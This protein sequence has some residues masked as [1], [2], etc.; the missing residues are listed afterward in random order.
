MDKSNVAALTLKF[1][2]VPQI[3]ITVVMKYTPNFHHS[4]EILVADYIVQ[5]FLVRNAMRTN[6]LIVWNKFEKFLSPDSP[7]SVETSCSRKSQSS[8]LHKGRTITTKT[9]GSDRSSDKF[10]WL[11]HY[12]V[13]PN[14]AVVSSDISSPSLAS[15]YSTKLT[16]TIVFH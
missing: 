11:S 2:F 7:R 13:E 6:I 3:L 9:S 14:T 15:G 16:S 10:S 1:C 5:K 12:S 8:P 4:F